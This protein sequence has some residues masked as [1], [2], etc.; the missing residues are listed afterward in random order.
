MTFWYRTR[1]GTFYI[2]P[3]GKRW[4]V[5]YNDDCLDSY[6]TPQQAAEDLAG[7]HGISPGF[8]TSTLG[9]PSDIGN[10]QS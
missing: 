8:D 10:W 7:G 4:G 9:I 5:F 3:F 1:R 6:A 2:K